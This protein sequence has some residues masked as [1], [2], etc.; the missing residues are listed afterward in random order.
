LGKDWRKIF[1]QRARE[2]AMLEKL[3]LPNGKPI[4]QVDTSK[5]GSAKGTDKGTDNTADE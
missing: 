4:E 3:D 1:R 5:A 2:N